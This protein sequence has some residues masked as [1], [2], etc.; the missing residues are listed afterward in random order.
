MSYDNLM[1]GVDGLD[2]IIVLIK[3]KILLSSIV[4][5]L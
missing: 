3:L 1:N 4:T 5:S 2:E